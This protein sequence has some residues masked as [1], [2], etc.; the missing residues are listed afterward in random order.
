M[1][2]EIDDN[3]YEIVNGW[4]KDHNGA[5]FM[6]KEIRPKRGLMVFQ[7]EAPLMAGFIYVSDDLTMGFI[8]YIVT[9]LGLSFK[10]KET[11]LNEL[12]VGFEKL[13]KDINIKY[14]F[15]TT[16]QASLSNK[17]R[18][19]GYTECDTDVVHLVKPI[20]GE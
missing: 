20:K 17:F 2:K 15:T 10:I 4:W 3:L 19:L 16:N 18:K 8:A 6:D 11:A 7:D 14:L 1:I 13:A 12:N 5:D 9:P